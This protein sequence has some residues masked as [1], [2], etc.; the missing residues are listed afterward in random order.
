MS[1]ILLDTHVAMWTVAGELGRAAAE[2]VKGAATRGDLLISPI[3]AWEIGLLASKQRIELIAPV[4]AYIRTLFS[5]PGVVT[6]TLTPEIAVMS[7][8]LPGT[9]HADPADRLLIA[10]AAA[11]GAQLLTR[12]K[13]ILAYAKATKHIRCIAC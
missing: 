1:L 7:S 12:D 8:C 6:A 5:Q 3:S 2:V 9:F 13:A 4:G 10:T 11:Y